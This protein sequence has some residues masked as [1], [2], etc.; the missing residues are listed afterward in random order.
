MLSRYPSRL[1]VDHS[2]AVA[3]LAPATL[4]ALPSASRTGDHNLCSTAPVTGDFFFYTA[5]V[6]RSE[7]R[8]ER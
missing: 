6:L 1:Y 2:V 5:A 8:A 7:F 4:A 3:T